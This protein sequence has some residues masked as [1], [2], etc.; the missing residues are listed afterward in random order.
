[1]PLFHD[2]RNGSVI[3]HNP[4]HSSGNPFES[5]SERRARIKQ[6]LT[7]IREASH[8]YEKSGDGETFAPSSKSDKLVSTLNQAADAGIPAR[9]RSKALR[10]GEKQGK[11]A[12]L[13]EA[14]DN[15]HEVS[16]TYGK[17]A[18]EKPRAAESD[19]EE[20][21]SD[22]LFEPKGREYNVVNKF[23]GAREDAAKAGLS[24]KKIDKIG[25]KGFAKGYRGK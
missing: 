23:R 10:Q 16:H 20:K 22:T 9:K 6:H 12:R 19:Y 7:N 25:D 4:N 14:A 18:K 5:G 1:M 15:L 8:D 2:R 17:T 11:K 21:R 13:K 24:P 3:E